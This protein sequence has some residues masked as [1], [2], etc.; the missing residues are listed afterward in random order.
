MEVQRVGEPAAEERSSEIGSCVDEA[1]DPRVDAAFSGDAEC[2]WEGEIGAVG[3]S[4]I[5]TSGES[6]SVC[7]TSKMT[8]ENILLDAGTDRTQNDCEIQRTGLAPLVR[9]LIAQSFELTVIESFDFLK[10]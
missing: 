8:V 7:C 10:I 2:F 3:A 9:S 5:P 4:L 1:D 6:L